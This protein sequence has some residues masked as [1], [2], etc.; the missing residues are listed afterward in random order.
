[1]QTLVCTQ[2]VHT[3]SSVEEK[4]PVSSAPVTALTDHFGAHDG[5]ETMLSPFLQGM[6][7]D[8]PTDSMPHVR[9]SA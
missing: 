9:Q 6:G 1:M 2:V 8:G 4:L 3:F 7:A 5:F